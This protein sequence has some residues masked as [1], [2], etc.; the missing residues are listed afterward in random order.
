MVDIKIFNTETKTKEIFVPLSDTQVKIYQCGPTVYWNQHIGNM[1]AVFVAD[2]IKR[3][4]IYND[5]KVQLVRNYTDVGHLT[6]DNI[7]DADTGEDRMEKAAKREGL[8]PEQIADK[9]IE[10]YKKDINLLNTLTPENTPKATEHI[11]DIIDMVQKLLDKGLAYIT[12]KAIYFDVSKAK[13]YTRLSGQ[14]LEDL[15]GGIGHGDVTDSAKKNSADFAL[16]F[17][18]TGVHKNI[19][20]YWPS[21]FISTEVEKGFG[22]PGWH[23]ECS[24][25]SKHFLGNTLDIHIGGIEH[26]PVHHTNE[27]A[28]SENANGEKYVNYWIHNEHLLVDGKKMSKSEGTSFLISDLIEKNYSPIALR[29]FFLQAHLRSKQNFTW[30]SLTASKNAY[31]KLL[32]F[33]Q[34]IDT[35]GDINTEYKNKFTEFINDDFNTAGALAIV[36]DLV[37]DE[38]IKAV[39]KKATI[40]DFNRVLGLDLDIKTEKKDVSDEV[41]I[42]LEK[43]AFARE[44]KNWALSDG[45][46][47]EIEKLGYS[48]KDGQDGQE[49][50]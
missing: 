34:N 13:N 11:D 46:R 8:S 39:D 49:I 17:F 5:F 7:G 22:F 27:I 2:I 29:Y 20:Q 47:K 33:Y 26:I 16:W 31:E 35:F 10:I 15:K 21:P 38:S 12:S 9:Y 25:M 18:K 4:F 24:A 44:E 32:K 36:W 1:R 41:K 14:K 23:I 40:V 50:S 45:I 6:G 30:E 3:V 28:Q 43:R 37:K 42:L 19:L 48:V